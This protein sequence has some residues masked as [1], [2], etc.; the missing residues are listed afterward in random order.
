MSVLDDIVAGVREDLAERE[1]ALPLDAVKALAANA[2]A[3]RDAVAALTGE[4]VAVIADRNV[5]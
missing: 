2:P 3:P 5:A 1:R 4:G